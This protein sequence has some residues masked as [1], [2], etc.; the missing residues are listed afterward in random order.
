MIHTPIHLM[1]RMHA[2]MQILVNTL[3]GKNIT[4]DVEALD[5]IDNVKA[6][7]QDK[8]DIP[9]DHDCVVAL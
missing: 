6:R 7:F 9:L 8:E 1:F 3:P 2:D 5:L 4:F